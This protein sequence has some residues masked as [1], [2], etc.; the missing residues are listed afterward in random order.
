METAY[1]AKGFD[2]I[3]IITTIIDEALIQKFLDLGVKY[4]STRTIG[5]DH[6]DV[7]A[8][9]RLGMHVGNAT[10]SANSVADY[11]IMLMLMATRLSLIHI[12]GIAGIIGCGKT[13]LCEAIYGA[14]AATSGSLLIEGKALSVKPVSYTHLRRL[15]QPRARAVNFI[16]IYLYIYT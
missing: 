6:I 1:L 16:Q 8:A 13:E 14:R 3:S 12:F 7:G 10:Y 9:R 4:I 2:C 5:Y 15:S 11:T